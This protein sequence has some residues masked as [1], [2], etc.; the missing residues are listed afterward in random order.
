MKKELLN[1]SIKSLGKYA[2][3]QEVDPSLNSAAWICN[4]LRTEPESAINSIECIRDASV[5]SK[6]MSES[7]VEQTA[8]ELIAWKMNQNSQDQRTLGAP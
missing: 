8:I 7:L 3:H 6:T 4:T 2:Y 5:A 1:S